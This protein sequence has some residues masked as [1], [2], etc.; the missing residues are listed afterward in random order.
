MRVPWTNLP[1]VK[2]IAIEFYE[3]LR[4]HDSWVM[5]LVNFIM[6]K[7][8]GPQSRLGRDEEAHS[9]GRKVHAK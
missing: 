1:K 8:M 9:M 2:E 5:C 7:D 4:S 3:P 6:S